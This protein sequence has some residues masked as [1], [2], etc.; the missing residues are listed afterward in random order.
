MRISRRNASA[1][2]AVISAIVAHASDLAEAAHLTRRVEQPAADGEGDLADVNVTRGI[3]RD[4]VRRDEVTGA[5][6]LLRVA[7]ACEQ[8]AGGTE[9]FDAVAIAGAILDQPDAVQ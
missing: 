7:K 2:A 9:D 5:F 1:S 3:D 8:L 4:A 6:A